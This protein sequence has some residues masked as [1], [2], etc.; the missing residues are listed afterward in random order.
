MIT[1]GWTARLYPTKAQRTRLEL[2]A[3]HARGVWNRLVAAEKAQ[4]E[5]DGTFLW[6]REL[7]ALVVKWKHEPETAWMNELPAHA[8]LDV[9]D[10]LDKA[11]RKMKSGARFPRFKKKRWGQGMVYFVNQ[12]TKLSEGRIRLPKLGSV[13]LRGGDAPDG[14]LMGSRAIRDGDRW[15]LSA[16]FECADPEPLPPTDIRVGIDVGLR[17]I[18]TTFDGTE[19]KREKAPRPLRKSLKRLR[20]AQRC[21]ARRQKHS[22]RRAAQVRRVAAIHRKVRCKRSDFLHKLSDRLTTKADHLVVEDID[23]RSIGR[24]RFLGLLAADAALGELLRQIAYKAQ[25]RGRTLTI[26]ERGFASTATCSQCGA[27]HSMPLGK[28]RMECSCGNRSHRDDNAAINLYW[29]PK[30]LG[31]PRQQWRDARGENVR[32]PSGSSSQGSA[33]AGFI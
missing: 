18:V 23:V 19:T 15:Q 16:Q 14:K 29:Y 8:L 25:W 30:E 1:V 9:C 22:Q 7:Q 28:L 4:Y 12:A 31:E 10:R 2:W 27:V 6:K 3:N 32:L 5:K 17:N 13:R 11:L 26:A 33:N 24:T 20:R 21:L